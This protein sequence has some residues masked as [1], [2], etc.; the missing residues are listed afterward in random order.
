MTKL[1]L[2]LKVIGLSYVSF[3]LFWDHLV[4]N[5]AAPGGQGSNGGRF[6]LIIYLNGIIYYAGSES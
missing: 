1:T 2:R 4:L 5:F 3:L 6:L